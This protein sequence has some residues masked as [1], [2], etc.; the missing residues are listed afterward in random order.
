[1]D[2]KIQV[3]EDRACEVEMPKREKACELRPCAGLDW[4]TSEWSGVSSLN[5]NNF[6]LNKKVIEIILLYVSQSFK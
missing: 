1:M 2:G 3:L 6:L 4:V 5:T